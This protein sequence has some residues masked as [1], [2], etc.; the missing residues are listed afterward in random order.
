M[1]T[2]LNGR[3]FNLSI[4]RRLMLTGLVVALALLP[5]C[6]GAPTANKSDK[7][8]EIRLDYA[9][10]NLSSLVLKKY[11]WLEEEFSKDGI[12]ITWLFSAGSNKAN[13]YISSNSADLAST[14]GAAALLAR[15]NGVPLKTVYV[16][17]KPEWTALVVP[18]ASA[19]QSIADL[20]GKKIAATRGT[21]PFFFLLR[22]LKQAGLSQSD[23]EIVNLQHGD[24]RLALQKGD[25]DAWAGL[26]PHMA[27]A[28]LQDGARLLYRNIDLISFGTLNARE[29]FAQQYPDLLTRI[30]AQYERARR[31]ILENREEAAK[32]L[33]EE[34]KIDLEIAR[35]QITERTVL[36]KDVGVPGPALRTALEAVVPIL[37]SE[38]LVAGNADPSA[39][40]SSLID[41]TFA[42]QA[43]QR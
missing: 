3:L 6:A 41:P 28:E 1:K 19:I 21:D 14:A 32:L 34:A 31:W 12:R 13:E 16:Y 25:V 24:G 38:K 35:R 9:T 17:S 18:G 4:Q 29:E 27:A 8:A 30:L 36:D 43:V 15:T 26:D 10:Y 5:A 2:N 42:Q 7:P 20:K 40:L 37:V 33:A 22:S 39:A 11:G 23:V